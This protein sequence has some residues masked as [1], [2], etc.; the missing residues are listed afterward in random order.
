MSESLKK[1]DEMRSKILLLEAIE[2]DLKKCTTVAEAQQVVEEFKI[3]F[4]LGE[5]ALRLQYR[6]EIAQP[7]TLVLST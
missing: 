2:A 4:K 7:Q 1:L 6:R 3:L 5:N